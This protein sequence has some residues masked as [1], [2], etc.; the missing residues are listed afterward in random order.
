[1]QAA[2]AWL[3]HPQ[4]GARCRAVVILPVNAACPGWSH[5]LPCSAIT[6]S[7][8]RRADP[9]RRLEHGYPTPSLWPIMPTQSSIRP[10]LLSHA[11]QDPPLTPKYADRRLEHGYPTPSL[12]RDAVLA[13]ALPWLR[14]Q[15]IWSRGRFGSYKYEVGNQDHSLMLGVECAD[16]VLFGTKVSLEDM[17]WMTSHM[18]TGSADCALAAVRAQLVCVVSRNSL[19]HPQQPALPRLV[20]ESSRVQLVGHLSVQQQVQGWAI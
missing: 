9:C 20:P 5:F 16:N 7:A 18:L 8:D 17:S 15:K 2:G 13:E 10:G 11:V 14:E 1:M 19:H 3:P 6:C 12:G 4:P